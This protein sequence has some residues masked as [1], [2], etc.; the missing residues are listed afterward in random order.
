MLKNSFDEK[1][2]SNK[3]A[4][5]SWCPLPWSHISIRNNGFY[6]VCCHSNVS[7]GEGILKD[8]KKK[9]F[10]VSSAHWSELMNSSKMKKIRKNMLQG[11]WSKECIRCQ[12]EYELGMKSRNIY[13]RKNLATNIESLEDYPSYLKAKNKTKKDGSLS[14][15]DFPASFLDIRFG[16]LCNLKCIMCGPTE[17]NKWYEDISFL[18]KQNYFYDS[19]IKNQLYKKGKVWK[20]KKDIYNWS[21]NSHFWS[22]MEKHIKTIRR[23]YIVGGEPFLIKAHFDF[24]Q[25]CIEES[26]SYKIEL[27]YNSN[28]T[29][30]PKRAWEIWKHFKLVKVLASVDGFGKINDFIRYP[31]KWSSIKKNLNRFN[32]IEA[33]FSVT[34]ASSISVLNIWHFPFFL[35]KLMEW[36]FKRSDQNYTALVTS[37]PVHKPIYLNINILEDEFKEKLTKRFDIFNKKISEFNWS[38][39]YGKSYGYVWKIKVKRVNQVLSHYKRYLYKISFSKEELKI[40]RKYFILYMDSLDKIRNTNWSEVLPELYVSTLSWRKL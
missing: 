13:E 1:M 39:K 38:E 3:G 37:H 28:V 14:I 4:P 21:E 9:A 29:Q 7:E 11:K 8:E 10:H 25:K 27:E 31:S 32:S 17:S 18:D 16:N 40:Q 36:N 15:S 19:G 30:I 2:K 5:A 22:Q 12:R 34:F 26:V 33:P 6:R 20:I 35:Q 23:L 24:L